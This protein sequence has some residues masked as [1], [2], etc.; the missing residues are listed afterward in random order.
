MRFQRSHRLSG[1]LQRDS[2]VFQ[3]ISEGLGGFHNLYCELHKQFRRRR[4]RRRFNVF[5]GDSEGFRGVVGGLHSLSGEFYW[6][7]KGVSER[8]MRFC[9]DLGV[10]TESEV[11]FPEISG[12]FWGGDQRL[13][14]AFR[15]VSG[16]STRFQRCFR[17]FI[18]SQAAQG[19]QMDF[20]GTPIIDIMETIDSRRPD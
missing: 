3:E 4:F 17:S 8:F 2:E 6:G 18:G 1:E 9:W 20:R 11:C 15:G 13:I 7:S 14:M 16:G 19:F 5:Q 10:F 12:K